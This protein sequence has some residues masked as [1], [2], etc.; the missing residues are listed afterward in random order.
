MNLNDFLNSQEL[1]PP[2]NLSDV[3]VSKV[4][5]DLNPSAQR[6]FGK[7]LIIHL[8]AS[9]V[10]LSICSQ[11]GIQ[12]FHAFDLMHV[13][14]SVAG[15]AYCMSFCGALFLGISA[16]SIAFFLR[17]EELR[18]VS[19]NAFLQIALLTI[20]SLAALFFL[21]AEILLIPA[22]LWLA[23][24]VGV[25]TLSLKVGLRVRKGLIM[26]SIHA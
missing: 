22:L 9:A 23:G 6:V 19:N 17:I 3:I 8:I 26:R 2:K 25:G 7:I 15:S 20:I 18:K 11:F 1:T 5:R 13:F 16:F 14:M 10:T 24:A 21:G 12:I 4:H